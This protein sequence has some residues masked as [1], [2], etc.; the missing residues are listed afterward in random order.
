[1]IEFGDIDSLKYLLA[2]FI[3]FSIFSITIFYLDFQFPDRLIKFLKYLTISI[4]FI[5]LD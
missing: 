3:Q 4:L 5:S 2:R 1:M